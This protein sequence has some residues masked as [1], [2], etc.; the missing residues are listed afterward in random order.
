MKK[1][2]VIATFLVVG[3]G[4]TGAS[5][6][7]D[8]YRGSDTLFNVTTQAIAA[9]GL[10]PTNAY[11]GG[12]SG[13]AESAMVGPTAPYSASAALQQTGPMSRM[14]KNASNLCSFNGGSNGSKDTSASSI[15]IGLDAVDIM[16]STLAGGST[17]CNGTADNTGTGLAYSGTTGVF[18]G[19]NTGQTWKWVLALVYGGKDLSPGG[20]TDCNSTARQAL[21]ANWSKLFQNGCK[22]DSIC[23][24]GTFANGTLWHAFRRDDTSGTSD[25]FASL[26]GLSPSTSSSANNGFGTSPYCNALNWDT[27]TGNANCALGAHK[28]W[29]GPGG[30]LDPVANDGVHRRPPVG[31]WGDNPDPTQGAL[32]ADVLPTQFQDN[33]PIRRTCQGSVTGNHNKIGE[34]V[35]NLDG[36]LGLVL[37]MPDSDWML[38]HTPP[39]KQYPTNVCNSFIAGKAAK[40]FTCAI[41]GTGTFHSGECPNGDS[42]TNGGCWVPVDTVNNTSQCTASKATSAPTHVRT[43]NNPDGRTYNVQMRDGTMGSGTI[44]YAQYPVPSIGATFDFAGGY[45]RIHEAETIVGSSVVACQ[46]EDMTDQIGCLMQ[47]DPCSI[48]YAGNEGLT[49]ASRTNGAKGLGGTA[50]GVASERVDQIQA[51]TASVQKL[52]TKGEYELSRKVYFASLPGFNHVAASTGDPQAADELTLAKFEATAAKINPILTS[53]GFFTLGSQ[54]PAGTDTPFCEDFNEQNICGASSNTNGCTG[55]PSGIPTKGTICGDGVQGPYEECDDGVKNGTTGDHCSLT[56]RC[57][58]DFNNSTGHCN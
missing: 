32:G 42:L 54:S 23:G 18:A 36:K 43:L 48:G 25:V 30:I 3:A 11:V 41:R 27:S 17:A 55:N 10:K 6:L 52:G 4:A 44:G 22:G 56:C 39:L 53:D 50:G 21:V 40:V 8:P 35:C 46:M 13:N 16:S 28:Q 2:I 49:F 29:T 12:G 19:G 45:S 31:T 14:M 7:V 34:E 9:A 57:T 58:L 15:A 24:A 51:T 33:D 5:A 1:S 20:V 47:A 37:P 26:L 38:Q